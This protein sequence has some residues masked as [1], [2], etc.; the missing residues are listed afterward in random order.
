MVGKFAPIGTGCFSLQLDERA[1]ERWAPAEP[2]PT[3]KR[4]RR[5]KTRRG[6]PEDVFVRSKG[7]SDLEPHRPQRR[8]R[9][10]TAETGGSGIL[11]PASPLLPSSPSLQFEEDTTATVADEDSGAADANPS[12]FRP[13]SPSFDA[14]DEDAVR[15]DDEETAAAVMPAVGE[16]PS[17]PGVLPAPRTMQPSYEA[18]LFLG[19]LRRRLDSELAQRPAP[20]PRPYSSVLA[21][22]T[23]AY[24]SMRPWD[25]G[26]LVR[27][28]PPIPALLQYDEPPRS[29]SPYRPSTPPLVIDQQT[30]SGPYRPSTPP[31][32]SLAT[33]TNDDDEDDDHAEEQDEKTEGVTEDVRFRPSTPPTGSQLP[34]D[35]ETDTGTAMII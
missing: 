26:M 21:V 1:L 12:S 10:D 23:A 31:P 18:A 24:A 25:R 34:D 19:E 28:E 3:K 8:R 29:A 2:V 9:A 15:S 6:A 16:E 22:P 20:L 30:H 13:S 11:R 17:E 14:M 33:D 32:A 35:N 4:A 7:F 5:G 27:E